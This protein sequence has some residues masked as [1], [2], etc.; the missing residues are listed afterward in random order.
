M[1]L[2]QISMSSWWRPGAPRRRCRLAS[3]SP[4]SRQRPEGGAPQGPSGPSG[5]TLVPQHRQSHG[6]D[7]AKRKNKRKITS[8][9]KG[10]V[11][12][13]RPRGMRTAAVRQGP[14]VYSVPRES[15]VPWPEFCN[16]INVGRDGPLQIVQTA[17]SG[18]YLVN[19]PRGR[20]RRGADL[21]RCRAGDG[22]GLADAERDM[23]RRFP[24]VFKVRGGSPVCLEFT[25]QVSWVWCDKSCDERDL[26]FFTRLDSNRGILAVSGRDHAEISIFDAATFAASSTRS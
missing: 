11:P 9:V 15:S 23:R 16:P 24:E 26:H 22:P 3:P 12:S 18:R 25:L 19:I 17:K 7:D 1:Q 8:R 13:I 2:W 20:S 5:G 14:V 21:W 10:W 6:R 4:A